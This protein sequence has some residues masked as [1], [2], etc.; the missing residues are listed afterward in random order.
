LAKPGDLA[1]VPQGLSANLRQYFRFQAK[2]PD[3]PLETR[4]FLNAG[5]RSGWDLGECLFEVLDQVVDV[6]YA[7]T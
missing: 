6:F 3:K 5:S 1:V 4:P 7:N 2:K